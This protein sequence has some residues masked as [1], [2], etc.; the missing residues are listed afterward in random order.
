MKL[1]KESGNGRCLNSQ[2]YYL[3]DMKHHFADLLDRNGEYWTILPNADRYAYS[4]GDVP[5]GSIHV[6]QSNLL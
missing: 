3:K 5:E 4:I 2:W 6:A 1:Q